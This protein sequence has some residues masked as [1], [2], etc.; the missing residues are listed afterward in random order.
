MENQKER[1]SMD[2]LRLGVIRPAQ[3][4]LLGFLILIAAGTLLLMLPFATRSGSSTSLLD[5]LFTATSA[6]CVT[7]LVVADTASHWSAFGHVVILLLIQIGGMGVVTVAVFFSILSGKKIG[8][9]QRWVMQE[10]ISA[11]HVGGILRQ[12]T[13]ILKT[14]FLMEALGAVLL[15]IRFVPRFGLG[16]GLWYAVFHSISAFCNAGFD[17]MGVNAPFSSLTEFAGD[18]L[19]VLTVCGLILSGGIGFLVWADMRDHKLKLREYSL[20]SKLVLTVTAVLLLGGFAFFLFEFSQPQW[21][22]LSAG[23]RVLAAL[24]QTVTPRTAG[25]NTVDLNTL[26][27]PGLLMTILLML[28]GGSTGSTAGGFKVNTLAVLVLGMVAAFQSKN[29]AELFGRRLPEHTIRNAAAIFL[30]YLLLFLGGGMVICCVDRIPLLG[31]LFETSSAV[32]TVGLTLGYTPGLSAVSHIV[33]IVLM[34]VGRVGGLTLMYGVVE[35]DTLTGAV[36][37]PMENVTVG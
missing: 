15:A 17:L 28:V 21:A 16:K 9:K 22:E 13:F 27:E 20:Q 31:A 36:R 32:A 18:P 25:F 30:L 8:L 11:P 10:S 6:S 12:T 23:E 26:S 19:V 37:L 14:A 2:R 3:I 4:I 24:F 7:G 33:L 5:A 29:S 34:Y 35:Q 1:G